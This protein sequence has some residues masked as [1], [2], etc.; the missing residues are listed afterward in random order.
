MTLEVSEVEDLGPNLRQIRLVGADLVGFAFLPGQDLMLRLPGPAGTLVSR[1]Y[2]IRR[3]D[4]A[5]GSADLN[6]VMHGDGPA[7]R[8]AK[9]AGPGGPPLE[10]TGP[11]GKITL[12]PSADWHVFLGDETYIP[13]AL[14]LLE[15]L[16]RGRRGWAALEVEG[17]E[18][19]QPLDPAA[20]VELQWL[21]RGAVRPGDG[22]RLWDWL[23]ARPQRGGTGHFYVAAEVSV[24]LGL[25]DRLLR[26][27]VSRNQVSA[28]A[29]WSRT[30][31]NAPRGE[32]DEDEVVG[33]PG[34]ASL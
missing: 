25:R 20:E 1:R 2:S 23:E 22:S 4:R 3:A 10:V 28:K 34:P 29:Y 16:P 9:A 24:A 8:W 21:H 32:P 13:A 14:A 5:G 7:A 12:D 33:T 15:A 19:E 27:G 31:A 11:R 6:V 17:A 26:L 30:R 18:D